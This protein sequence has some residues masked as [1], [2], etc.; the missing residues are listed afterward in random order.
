MWRRLRI[1]SSGMVTLRSRKLR[2]WIFTL[3]ASGHANPFNKTFDFS[4]R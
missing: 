4:Y 1:D 3:D 2:F